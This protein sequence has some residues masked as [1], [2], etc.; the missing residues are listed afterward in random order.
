MNILIKYS[1]TLREFINC[2]LNI[3]LLYTTVLKYYAPK[4]HTKFEDSL[5]SVIVLRYAVYK[6]IQLVSRSDNV[7][8]LIE[9][10]IDDFI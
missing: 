2:F 10:R 6:H 1:Y 3:I 8:H 9:W 4:Q 5:C 7:L